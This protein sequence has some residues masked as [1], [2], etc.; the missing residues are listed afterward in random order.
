M[1]YHFFKIS[2]KFDFFLALFHLT[3]S[4]NFCNSFTT[5]ENV[6][7]NRVGLGRDWYVEPVGIVF[8]TS[9]R[10]TGSWYTL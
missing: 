2:R 7:K 9:F 8:N 4:Y 5:R 10:Y 6:R 1:V 3:S